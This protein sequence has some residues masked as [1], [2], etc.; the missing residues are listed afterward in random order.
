MSVLSL[1]PPSE[2]KT[3][4]LQPKQRIFA[5]TNADIAIYGGSAGGGKSFA[6]LYDPIGKRHHLRRGF[7]AVLFRRSYPEI[8]NPGGLWDEAAEIYTY[9]GGRPVVGAME[10]RFPGGTKITFRHLENEETKLRYQGSQICYLAFDELT[11]FNESQFWY[12]LS[13]NRSVC[14]V[15]PYVRATCNPDPGWVKSLLAPWVDDGFTGVRA[16]SG[17]LR[18]FLRDAGLIK[19]VPADTPDAKSLTFIRASV[20]DN[21]ALLERDPGYIANLKALPAVERARLLEGDWNVRREGLVYTRFED[22]VFESGPTEK[23]THGAIDFGFNHPFA[24]VWGHLTDDVLW[25]TGCR[26][27]RGL[28]VGEHSPYLPRGVRWWCDPS[29]PDSRVELQQAGHDVIPCVHLSVRG[30]AGSPR[31]PVLHGIDQVTER[32]RTGRLKIVR[33]NCL[34]LVRGLSMYH[35]DES[36]ASEEP[37]KELDDEV[38]ALRYLIVGL[39]RG[40]SVPTLPF[41]GPPV[42]LEDESLWE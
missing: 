4:R 18:W 22:S 25:I 21:P 2:T 16:L 5:R 40:R 27:V 29:R 31:T 7:S 35:Y 15:R 1:L 26:S 24:A 6:L 13:R 32:M 8:T 41:D 10:Y 14:G 23:P 20:Y 17:E 9:A 34:P 12:L 11:H 36:K 42:D 3:F 28:T 39:D 30:G 19:W 37:V 38:D 33:P